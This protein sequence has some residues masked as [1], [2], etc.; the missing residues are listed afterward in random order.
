MALFLPTC[1]ADFQVTVV[2]SALGQS[3]SFCGASL[4]PIAQDAWRTRRK[5]DWLLMPN[6]G[7]I[8]EGKVHAGRRSKRS[9]APS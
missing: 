8:I 1:Y 3:V 9:T 5:R 7:E 4:S 2:A 6:N